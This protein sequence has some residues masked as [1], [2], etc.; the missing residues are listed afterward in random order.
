MIVSGVTP[1]PVRSRTRSPGGAFRIVV[2]SVAAD[3]AN[4]LIDDDLGDVGVGRNDNLVPGAGAIDA[5]LERR[6]ARTGRGRRE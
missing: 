5:G 1:V 3:E 4:G 2:F 6:V